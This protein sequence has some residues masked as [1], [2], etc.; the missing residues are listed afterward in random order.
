MRGFAAR[1][2]TTVLP[3]NL[4]EYKIVSECSAEAL[5]QYV[6]FNNSHTFFSLKIRIMSADLNEVYSNCKPFKL[7]ASTIANFI[8]LILR[9]IL[10][11]VMV[12]SY[13]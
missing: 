6:V 12:A 4:L 3:L 11:N 9:C 13:W 2:L 1:L 10:S 5:R 7:V 8:T